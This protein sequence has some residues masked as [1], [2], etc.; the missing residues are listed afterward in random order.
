MVIDIEIFNGAIIVNYR[1][2]IQ[3]HNIL[4]VTRNR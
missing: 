1:I 4:E 2:S 3:K